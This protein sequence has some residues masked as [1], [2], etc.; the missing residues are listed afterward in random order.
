MYTSILQAKNDLNISAEKRGI[1]FINVVTC[2]QRNTQT[3]YTTILDK[4]QTKKEVQEKPSFMQ[5]STLLLIYPDFTDKIF[6]AK[7]SKKVF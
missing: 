7:N 2:F 6:F 3:N 1:Q 5:T 4:K